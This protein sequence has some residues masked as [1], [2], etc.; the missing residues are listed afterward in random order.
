MFAP[1]LLELGNKALETKKFHTPNYYSDAVDQRSK[2]DKDVKGVNRYVI[3][4]RIMMPKHIRHNF[5]TMVKV[6]LICSK[7][8]NISISK[9]HC[10]NS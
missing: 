4:K 9:H 8:F 7:L 10:T 3:S 1:K 6:M 2:D 5:I